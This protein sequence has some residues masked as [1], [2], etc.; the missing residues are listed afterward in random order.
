MAG[1]AAANADLAGP[2]AGDPVPA[3]SAA[4]LVAAFIGADGR[5]TPGTISA[6]AVV[7]AAGGL[8]QAFGTT[9]NLAGATGD[10]VATSRPAPVR[11]F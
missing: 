4:G 5:L 6:Q 8:G 11:S 10:G 3:R 2:L 9:P 1:T 7:I